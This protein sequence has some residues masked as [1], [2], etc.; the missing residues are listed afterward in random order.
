VWWLSPV[1]LAI[2]I[3]T[4]KRIMVQSDPCIKRDPIAKIS[5]TKRA[6]G[7]AQVVECLPSEYVGPEFNP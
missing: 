2:P 5:N 4:N 1:I 3:S 6:D 7:M